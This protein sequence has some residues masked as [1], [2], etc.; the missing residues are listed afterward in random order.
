MFFDERFERGLD[1]Y[2]GH[3]AEPAGDQKRGEIAPTYFDSALALQRLAQLNPNLRV[4]INV[5]D[6]V[7][8]TY[9]AF[10]HH[11][12]KGRVP[13]DFFEAIELMP[14]IETSGRYAEHCERWQRVFGESNCHFVLQAEVESV[15]QQVIDEVCRFLHVQSMT[16]SEDASQRFGQSTRPRW[17]V[18]AKAAAM[19]ST[20]LRSRGLHAPIELAKRVGLRPLI[21]GKPAGEEPIPPAVRE[22][23]EQL[24]AE[25]R[26]YLRDKFGARIT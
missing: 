22:Y 10:R 5:R 23:L 12:A 16:L 18:A 21:F 17:L 7:E 6:P 1:W 8:R 26:A 20:G 3:F 9:S 24:H 25:D 15:P 13:D 4:I 2:W 11:R 19:I 14:Q